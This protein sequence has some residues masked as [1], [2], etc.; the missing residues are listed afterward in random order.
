MGF[1]KKEPGVK[2]A[3]KRLDWE[4]VKINYPRA[5]SE[6]FEVLRKI[7]VRQ[8]PQTPQLEAPKNV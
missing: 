5:I 7:Q 8:T 6:S 1:S 3:L 2:E 4:S